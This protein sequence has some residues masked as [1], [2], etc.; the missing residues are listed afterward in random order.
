MEQRLSLI[1]LGVADLA[2]SRRFYEDGLGWTKGNSEEEVAFY[3]LNGLILALWGRAELAEDAQVPDPGATFSGIALAFTTR[4]H[5]EVDEVLELVAAADGTILKPAGETFWGG[6]SGYF[7]DPDGHPWEVA[8]NPAW[9][10]DEAGHV[11]LGS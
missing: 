1:T 4:N 7:A 9:P 3:Q 8:W 5:D 6:Y 10:I 11:S 2:R